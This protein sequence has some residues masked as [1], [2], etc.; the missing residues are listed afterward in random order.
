MPSIREQNFGYTS[1]NESGAFDDYLSVG[2]FNR[3][4]YEG[5]PYS[6]IEEIAHELE[7]IR[8]ELHEATRSID[9]RIDKA[10]LSAQNI[11]GTRAKGRELGLYEQMQ[12]RKAA[13]TPIAENL[14]KAVDA[15]EMSA[16]ELSGALAE[17]RQ[18]D[19]RAASIA[20]SVLDTRERIYSFVDR[21]A[22]DFNEIGIDV[23]LLMP[24]L[25]HR[26]NSEADVS[27]ALADSCRVIIDAGNAHDAEHSSLSAAVEELSEIRDALLGHLE[28]M[29]DVRER[30]IAALKERSSLVR[31]AQ[32]L[33]VVYR[34]VFEAVS[35]KADMPHFER[36][37]P[38]IDEISQYISDAARFAELTKEA[39]SQELI[40][41]DEA[42]NA[43]LVKDPGEQILELFEQMGQEAPVNR[44][45]VEVG[46]AGLEKS[47]GRPM[48]VPAK[49]T[50]PKKESFNQSVSAVKNAPS[51][52][53]QT[54]PQGPNR[55]R[56]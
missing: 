25:N 15:F 4:G 36:D 30:Q 2:D 35:L 45:V 39:I 10:L 48:A 23:N 19:Q 14:E 21:F 6:V 29:A 8:E 42:L 5:M 52:K 28:G 55:N 32:D 9:E 26:S 56:K 13:L 18:I 11:G 20:K 22:E 1:G 51:Q 27:Q 12:L 38:S 31:G 47:Q 43:R 17:Q 49:S 54:T 34:P 24:K 50:A 44:P 41:P 3:F 37:A 53:R 40:D 16:R 33:E 7:S 46:A